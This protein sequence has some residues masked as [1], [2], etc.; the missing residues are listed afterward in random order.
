MKR[1]DDPY[2]FKEGQFTQNVA[3][4]KH[5][6]LSKQFIEAVFGYPLAPLYVAL[7][8]ILTFFVP[9]LFPVTALAALILVLNFKRIDILP[10]HLPAFSNAKADRNNPKIGGRGFNRPEGVVYFGH[11]LRAGF[12]R[13]YLKFESVL[14]H[15]LVLGTTG[16]GKTEFLL[17]LYSNFLCF[18]SGVMYND[19]KGTLKLYHQGWTIARF[20]GRDMCMRLLNYN[21]GNASG[22]D[23]TGDHTSNT[24]APF[25][26]GSNDSGIQL[27]TS[28]LPADGGG[29]NAVFQ[30]SAVS[31]VAA[32]YPA[33][34]Y[35]RDI[36]F[37]QLD[38]SVIRTYTNYKEFTDLISNPYL[39]I[40]VRNAMQ[41]FV[42]GRG[43]FDA[44]KTYDKQPEEVRKQ[45]SYAQ[46]YLSRQ[47]SLLVDSYP[48]IYLSGTG[49]IDYRD[50]IL[51]NRLTFSLFP[52]IE[53]SA[54]EMGI[55]GKM[56]LMSQ[57][58]A[59][60][61][62]LGSTVQGD[63]EDVLEALPMASEIP[64]MIITD[65]ASYIVAKGFAVTTAQARGF[66]VVMVI[67][68]QDY[69]GLKRADADEAEQFVANTRVKVFLSSEAD[70]GTF[71]LIKDI[72]GDT[73]AFM[74]TGS[75]LQSG[76]VGYS[77]EMR[78]EYSLT[79]IDAI[80]PDDLRSL[81]EGEGIICYQDKAFFFRS[82][83]H[84]IER[85]E[86]TVRLNKLG[87][88]DF[89]A[90][91][92]HYANLLAFAN[93]KYFHETRVFLD[94]LN[95]S[96]DLLK[97]SPPVNKLIA[98]MV[99][100]VRD[101]G[102][103]N[104]GY[105]G[106]EIACCYINAYSIQT[107]FKPT[108]DREPGSPSGAAPSA[109]GAESIPAQ[110]NAP[111]GILSNLAGDFGTPNTEE[112]AH[113]QLLPPADNNAARVLDLTAETP[114]VVTEGHRT[115]PFPFDF[116]EDENIFGTATSVKDLQ[117]RIDEIF[118]E[119][120]AEE[121]S[122]GSDGLS[123]PG[124]VP[125]IEDYQADAFITSEEADALDDDAVADVEAASLLERGEIDHIRQSTVQLEQAIGA[126]AP[127]AFATGSAFADRIIKQT[128]YPQ[129]KPIGNGYLEALERFNKHFE[130]KL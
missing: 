90:T 105:S 19:A 62:G 52:P 122:P 58:A 64:F 20:F 5:K 23:D 86:P 65:E 44:T 130:E 78:T 34:R 22:D 25:S 60:A 39:P 119:A 104:A 10:L 115:A 15:M 110:P 97:G 69:S 66:K 53:K 91:R 36:N 108:R 112:T 28:F 77:R 61:I 41:Q 99:K 124:V 3:I 51:N 7:L 26:H 43:G 95:S 73:Y 85:L 100:T 76:M 70:Q 29:G 111:R 74:K 128:Q 11:L 125:D 82:F 106:A 54:E 8:S 92:G 102:A 35:L 96:V 117:S 67:S 120:D 107:P 129:R 45:Y 9:G 17:S 32:I 47:L 40:K 71:G 79:K 103:L 27:I 16:A 12:Q 18:C 114:A 31:L 94:N 57:K 81:N 30:Q 93:H 55:L 13:I 42:S 113:T 84:G 50:C 33:L 109:A 24:N 126:P 4:V 1:A 101:S 123:V 2:R 63:A 46:A 116:E 83:Y 49:E 121:G 14:R 68:G 127:E 89:K 59:L 72:I 87:K 37:L 80:T 6:P 75:E 56:S 48:N 38:P 118:R 98:A 21:K 88:C